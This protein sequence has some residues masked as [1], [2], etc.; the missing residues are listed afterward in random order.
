MPK[1]LTADIDPKDELEFLEAVDSMAE[2]LA[3]TASGG[4]LMVTGH[5]QAQWR[6]R[7]QECRTLTSGRR[8][9]SPR[10]R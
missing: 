9:H 2:T 3:R 10:K 1:R 7:M 4:K 5:Y 8:S 6:E